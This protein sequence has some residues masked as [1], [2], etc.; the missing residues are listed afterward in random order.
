MSENMVKDIF[1]NMCT[2]FL[3]EKAANDKAIIGFNLSGDNGGTYYARIE[4]GTCETGA[5]APPATADI[6]ISSDAQDFINLV[7]G[8]IS[9]I[10]AMTSGKFKI[11]GPMGVAMKFAQ[12]FKLG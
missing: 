8:K 5:G 2:Q 1:D 11:Q 9:P 4:N 3:P 10:I 7:T 12:W 6:T